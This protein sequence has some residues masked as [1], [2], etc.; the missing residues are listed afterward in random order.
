MD[1]GY[2]HVNTSISVSIGLVTQ[3]RG[4]HRF[5]SKIPVRRLNTRERAKRSFK[6]AS[7]LWTRSVL[8]FPLIG[9]HHPSVPVLLGRVS[10][11]IEAVDRGPDGQPNGETDPGCSRKFRHLK[12]GGLSRWEEFDLGVGR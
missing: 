7:N 10:P 6:L 9:W 4:K 11:T 12:I 1:F 3:K 8:V 5:R 2:P